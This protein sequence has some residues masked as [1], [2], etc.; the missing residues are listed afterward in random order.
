MNDLA[1]FDDQLTMRHV[2]EYPHPIERVWDAV[3]MTE[4]LDAW[5]LPASQVERREG[6]KCSF[7]WGGPVDQ[8]MEETVAIYDPPHRVQ[9]RDDAGG[10]IQFDL[11]AIGPERTKLTFLQHFAA[12]TGLEKS[13]WPGGDQPAGPDTPWKPGFIAGFH[14]FLDQLGT[15]LDGG[16]TRE[17]AQPFIDV[18][19]SNGD[20]MKLWEE[21]P[22]TMPPANDPANHEPL[23]DIYREHVKETYPR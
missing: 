19:Y 3:T 5:M 23:I 22:E 7:S 18:V 12:G 15:Y 13:D 20:V 14:G 9:Y 21:R 6:G 16:W 2:R 17:Q 10:F 11:E 8:S 4:H 1:T